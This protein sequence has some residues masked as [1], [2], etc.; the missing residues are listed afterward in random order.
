MSPL[1]EFKANIHKR[2]R[3][4]LVLYFIV[5][6]L[7]LAVSVFHIV[8]DGANVLLSLVGLVLGILIG[9]LAS[10]MFKISWD[11]TSS[12]VIA[13]F[14]ALG[15]AILVGYVI[16]EIFR[17]K[18]V[19]QFVHGPSVIAVSFMVLAGLM[20]GRVLGTHGKIRTIFKEQGII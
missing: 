11:T 4:R 6:V 15:I 16:F 3:I 17:E 7:M 13:V 10:R 2:I 18:I 20:Y 14:D 8:K 9:V 1:T 12:Q 19:S 5:S